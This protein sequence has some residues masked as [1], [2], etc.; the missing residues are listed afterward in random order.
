M[1]PSTPDMLMR[2]LHSQP[3]REGMRRDVL[4]IMGLLLSAAL[5]TPI[6]YAQSSDA[7]AEEEV[8]LSLGKVITVGLKAVI[9]EY[10]E[11]VKQAITEHKLKIRELVEEKLQVI[12]ETHAKLKQIRAEIREE[13]KTL[14]EKFKAG[15]IGPEE[16]RA[17]LKLLMEKLRLLN[18]SNENLGAKI[19][20]L[21][22]QAK[23][24]SV[25]KLLERLREENAKFGQEVAA[26]ARAI[27]REAHQVRPVEATPRTARPAN[28][29]AP[30][31]R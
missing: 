26:E 31:G 3:M 5:A 11:Q 13:I 7:D 27:A 24:L 2:Y 15:E 12:E 14:Q 6:V 4:A 19:K 30:R 10:K 16:Y 29:T 28:I 21:S 20:Q 22:G 23:S 25:K 1:A 9:E 18:K 17:E 8:P